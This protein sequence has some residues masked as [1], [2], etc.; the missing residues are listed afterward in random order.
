MDRRRKM[1]SWIPETEHDLSLALSAKKEEPSGAASQGLPAGGRQPGAPFSPGSGLERSP[2]ASILEVGHTVDEQ[3]AGDRA[4][5][6]TY[7]LP[8]SAAPVTPQEDLCAFHSPRSFPGDPVDDRASPGR[9]SDGESPGTQ[10]GVLRQRQ[11][12]ASGS[13][14]NF[15]VASGGPRHQHEVTGEAGGDTHTE[16]SMD[17]ERQ[18]DAGLQERQR[19]QAQQDPGLTSVVS[20]IGA[21]AMSE[22]EGEWIRIEES[23]RDK[24]AAA[25]AP[26]AVPACAQP[27]D[28]EPLSD[29]Y[30]LPS[31]G[32]LPTEGAPSF[33]FCV[34]NAV[35]AGETSSALGS[36]EGATLGKLCAADC[37]YNPPESPCPSSTEPSDMASPKGLM[38]RLSAYGAFFGRSVAGCRTR[39]QQVHQRALASAAEGASAFPV[40]KKTTDVER[41]RPLR[42][43]GDWHRSFLDLYGGPCEEIMRLALQ[44]LPA[45]ATDYQSER[46]LLFIQ[47]LFDV[48]CLYRSHFL[49]PT[50]GLLLH[51]EALHQRGRLRADSSLGSTGGAPPSSRV[52]TNSDLF[53]AAKVSEAENEGDEGLPLSFR[54]ALYGAVSLALKIVRALQLLLELVLKMILYSL[55][56]FAFYCDEQSISQAVEIHRSKQ[57]GFVEAQSVS[58][59]HGSPQVMERLSPIEAAELR[60]RVTGLPYALLRPPFFDKFL[61]RPFEAVDYIVRRVP[62]LNHFKYV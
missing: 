23:C 50:E 55:T 54:L 1:R 19:Q 60:R 32:I 16:Q 37:K 57:V 61:A 42:E 24:P 59:L 9:A 41:S 15:L 47:G 48:F 18:L 38:S 35:Q 12:P 5:L 22:C 11:K 45:Q 36:T 25:V 20:S 10:A 30:P 34:G 21:S 62:L 33:P 14:K 46:R 13:Q 31:S 53:G 4:S 56:P 7:K 44:V 39:E 49:S 51:A 3:A 26:E 2:R 27:A 29:H 58:L 52:L 40:H 28:P 17:E 8:L 43:A 6:S